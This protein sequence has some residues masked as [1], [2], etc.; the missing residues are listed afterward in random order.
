MTPLTDEVRDLLTAPNLVHLATLMPDGSPHTVAVWA[1][2]EGDHI[3]FFTQPQSRKARNL[4]QDPR[5]ALSVVD[6]DNPYRSAR[7]RGRVVATHTGDEALAMIDRLS[8]SYI[9]EP[10]PMR[11][12]T[13]YEIEPEHAGFMELPFRDTPR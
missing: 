6:R 11:T 10:F 5:V 12:G 13:V 4:E 3:F 7:V 1:D 8:Q 9:G 2:L